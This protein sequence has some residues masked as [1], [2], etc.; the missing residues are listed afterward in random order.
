MTSKL[1]SLTSGSQHSSEKLQGSQAFSYV[2]RFRVFSV[3][4][5][6]HAV[7]GHGL[8]FHLAERLSGYFSGSV[9]M[10]QLI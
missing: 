8:R 1:Q 10:S 5:P 9:V 3:T 4:F 2:L 6:G 7:F